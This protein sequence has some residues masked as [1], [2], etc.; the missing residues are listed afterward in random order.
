MYL[1]AI[2]SATPEFSFTQ[3][4]CWDLFKDSPTRERLD[5]KS[6]GLIEKVLL[7]DSGIDR[8]HFSLSQMHDLFELSAEDLNRAFEREAPALAARALQ[9]AL[10]R[11]GWSAD[12]LDG[13]FICTCTGYLCPGISSHVAEKLGLPSHA[14]LQ[15]LVG[16][17]CGA[18]IPT[19][20]SAFHMTHAESERPLRVA[21]VAVEVCSAAFYL[22][23][24]PGVLISACIFSDGAAATLWSNQP[25]PTGLQAGGFDTVHIPEDREFLR[26][27]NSNGKLKNR[28]HRSVPTRAANAVESLYNR[29]PEAGDHSAIIA[30]SGG[31]DV[32]DALAKRFPG[33]DLGPSREVLR[34]YGNM[35]S[36]SVLFALESF[37]HHNPELPPD[38]QDLWLVSFGAGFSAH[39]CRLFK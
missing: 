16:L 37:L 23:D 14:Y 34:R 17:G 39:S 2:A 31:R 18:A 5:S 10:N 6:V 12:A 3:Q 4:Q 21:A 35:S 24:D 32:L 11:A 28:L 15:D 26:F 25:G 30:H 7:G 36:P 38:V 29:R 19:M 22:E 13:L 1:H 8:R 9:P 27:L 20:R 33:K